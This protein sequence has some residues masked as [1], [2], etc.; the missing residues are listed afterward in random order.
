MPQRTPRTRVTSS[1]ATSTVKRLGAGT[2][3]SGLVLAVLA[4]TTG[5][6]GTPFAEE[7]SAQNVMEAR[8]LVGSYLAGRM[9]Q[10]QRDA[11]SATAFLGQVLAQDPNNE[12]VLNQAFLNEMMLGNFDKA[13]G[14]AAKLLIM[15][16]NNRIARLTLGTKAFRERNWAEAEKQFKDDPTSPIGELTSRL[17]RA[18]VQVG[19]GDGKA[20]L[21][22]VAAL[23]DADWISFFRTYNTAL[24]ADAVGDKPTANKAFAELFAREP[25]TVA[26]AM[27]YTSFLSRSGDAAQARKVLQANLRAARSPHPMPLAA[28]D[29]LRRGQTMVNATA[30]PDQGLS[31]VFYGLGEALATEGGIDLGTIYVQLALRLQPTSPLALAAL[32]G[33]QEQAKQYNSAI[34]TYQRLPADAPLAISFALRRSLNLNALDRPDEAKAVLTKLLEKPLVD[35]EIDDPPISKD[36]IAKAQALTDLVPG[37]KGPVVSS[38]Q[39]ILGIA[40]YSAGTSDGMYGKSTQDAVRL[41]QTEAKLPVTGGFDAAT[42]AS[43]TKR[44]ETLATEPAKSTR[45]DTEIDVLESIGNIQ[46]GRK[47]WADAAQWYSRALT[48]AGTPTRAQWEL[49]YSRGICHERLKQ[50]EKAE[51]DFLQALALQPEEASVLNYLGYSWVDQ[52]RRL[53]EALDMIKKA[54]ALRPDDGYIVDSLGWAY[55]KLGRYDDAVE[56]LERAV[57]LRPDDSVL[58]DHLGDAFWRAGRRLEAKFQWSW[59]LSMKPEAEEIPKLKA[60]LASGL[61]DTDAPAAAAAN[62]ATGQTPA[63]VE[64]PKTP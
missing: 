64:P 44:L 39:E 58:N 11:R 23:Q 1:P 41:L 52:G 59:A 51:S 10:G 37:G 40:G 14:L 27:A 43:L 53:D 33:V 21:A 17:A 56:Q 50:W 48:L 45:H 38:L 18:W 25:R 47:E 9:A 63:P 2:K 3:W 7:Q 15:Q 8:T 31:Q 32:A 26:V 30:T 4:L 57:Q 13:D 19:R 42:R 62:N 22:T 54:V 5:V 34:E 60:K 35:I 36:W 12:I 55:Y 24:I 6:A 49:L 46:R 29:D 20:A 28:L 16:P 61:K